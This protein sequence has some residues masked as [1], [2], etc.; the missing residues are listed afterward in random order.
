MLIVLYYINISVNM[1]IFILLFFTMGCMLIVASWMRSEL[2]C[3]PQR[4]IYRYIPEHT[5][6]VQF[7]ETNLPSVI[8][9]DMFTQ[10]SPWIGGYG[11]GSGKTITRSNLNKSEFM[12]QE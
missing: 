6:D 4:V 11:L 12:E 8:Y 2:K 7:S 3:P 10:S 5:L 1:D 9:E